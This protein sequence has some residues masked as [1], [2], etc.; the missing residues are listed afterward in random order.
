MKRLLLEKFSELLHDLCT[1][2]KSGE[3][4]DICCVVANLGS[5][6]PTFYD[7]LL[8]KQIYA[9]LSGTWDRA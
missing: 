2:S 7:Q 9:D 3:K 1:K 6:S 4:R 8:R 5:M